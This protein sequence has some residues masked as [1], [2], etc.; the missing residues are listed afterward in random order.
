MAAIGSAMNAPM[1]PPSWP[2]ISSAKMT[3]NGLMRSAWPNTCGATTW[4]SSCCRTVKAMISHTASSGLS[5][6]AAITTGGIAPMAGPTY[7]ISSAKPYQAPKPTA[8]VLPSGKIPSEPNRN[9]SSP[10]L[11]PMITLNR[12]WPRT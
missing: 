3:S 5:L 12:S 9:R 7:G 4:P 8:Y 11:V 10:A 1:K 2:P 6:S